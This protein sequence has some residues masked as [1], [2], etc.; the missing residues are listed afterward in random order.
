MSTRSEM[1]IKLINWA[2]A[3]VP[4]VQVAI[5]GVPFVRGTTP[6]IQVFFLNSSNINPTLSGTRT[7]TRGILQVN[8]WVKDGKGP[9]VIEDIAEAIVALFPVV[10]KIGSV[11]VE[12][13]P[14]ISQLLTD[15]D[16]KI[17]PVQIKYRTEW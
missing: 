9:K 12:Q 7:R 10:P 15:E 13:T 16:W 3:Q 6:F 11:S 5:E 17:A 1:E 14:N 4:P 8:C 2:A